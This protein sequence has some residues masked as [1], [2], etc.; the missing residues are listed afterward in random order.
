MTKS[1]WA[2]FCLVAGLLLIA[3]SF[4][5]TQALPNEVVWSSEQ[6]RRLTQSA[7]DVHA[8]MSSEGVHRHET[9]NLQ[10]DSTDPSEEADPHRH[11]AEMMAKNEELRS[12]LGRARFFR[13]R[14]PGY[15][16]WAGL[17]MVV[18]SGGFLLRGDGTQ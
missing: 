4:V 11:A 2:T 7:A 15:L 1:K 18:F 3:G 6:A 17:A 13:F 12:E 16:R 10:D 5:W 14:M 8:E 9:S